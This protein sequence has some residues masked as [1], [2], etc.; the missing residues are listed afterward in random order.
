[1]YGG[2]RS[3]CVLGLAALVVGV[4]VRAHA[5]EDSPNLRRIV[6]ASPGN[7][8]LLVKVEPQKL[9]DRK[10]DESVAQ[11]PIDFVELLDSI[12]V[13]GK[14][15]LR[16]IQ[17]IQFDP[18]SGRQ[19]SFYEDYAYQRG[20]WDRA[21]RWY[22]DAIPYDFQ[23]VLGAS[24]HTDG[25]RKRSKTPRAGY[26]YNAVGEWKSGRLSW[27]HT[28]TGNEPSYYAIYFDV[29][30]ADAPPPD[31]APAGWLG[32]AMPRYARWGE[33]TTGA[34]ITRITL[35]DWNEDGLTDVVYGE[36]YGQSFYALNTGTKEHF[37]LG[38]S[39]MLFESDGL[40]MD[41]GMHSA[42]LVIDW[43][44]DGDKDLLIGT[45]EN[46]IAFF[47]NMGTN[48]N[49][50]FKYEGYLRTPDGE[51]L[52][53]PV[54]PVARKEPRVF[55]RDYF[56]M[57]CAVDWDDD[58]ELDL[59]AGGYITGRVYFFRNTGERNEGLP[60]LDLVGPVEADGKPINVRDWCAAPTVADFNAD[61]LLDLV[62]GAFTWKKDSTERPNFLRYYVNSGTAAEPKLSELPLPVKGEVPNLRLPSPQAI[63]ANDDGLVDLLVATGLDIVLYPNIGT[64]TEPLF[65]LDVKPM[66]SA[67]GN[68]PLPIGHQVLDWNKDGLPDL[69]N[70]YTV[71]LNSG[72][73]KPYFWNKTESVLP[74]GAR[75]D[76]PAEL[77][78]GHFYPYLHDVDH[79]GKIDVLFGDWYGHVW[80]HRNLSTD[81]EKRFDMEGILLMTAD[82]KPIKV[83]PI[84]VDTATNFQA[85][86]GARTTLN[87]GDYN[88]D[89][90][91]DLI[92]GDTYGMIRYYENIGELAAPRFALPVTVGD[93]KSRL[94]VEKGDWNRDGRLDV[95]AAVSTHKIYVFINEGDPGTARFGEP[96][97]LHVAVK[98]P[99]VMFVDL[100]RDGDDDLV[101]NGTQGTSFVERSYLEN[102]Y[103]Q[104]EI[105]KVETK[106]KN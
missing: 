64:K 78:D 83:G 40:P 39:K 71:H 4:G 1:M 82:G 53:L 11:V 104:A 23:E 26:V 92:V 66:R 103:A 25:E 59:L 36:Q 81:D 3:V 27:T 28:Q 56:P 19:T 24:S 97:L 96:I 88:G 98:N 57:L 14:A 73:G 89:G 72:V 5:D 75:I 8:R 74:M 29:M 93:L 105:L 101:I 50:V 13:K 45:Y 95:I 48:K 70:G 47:R 41:M 79:D 102:G 7:Y 90:L 87:S 6:W 80:F 52:A 106:S 16:T 85:L 43:D 63:D 34:D 38:P 77:G 51:F 99:I 33:N 20:P 30:D 100:N 35:D 86:Q 37:Q 17:V 65:D 21:F 49:R 61:G 18:K 54:T 67:W 44:A 46:R 2:V 15:D 32:D 55:V 76:H 58:G 69:V 68:A 12:G 60:V 84:D 42:P 9:G 94:Q 31:A 91:E 62:V 22:D 10:S